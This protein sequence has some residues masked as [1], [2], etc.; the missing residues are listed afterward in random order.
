[1]ANLKSRCNLTELSIKGGSPRERKW[2]WEAAIWQ[3]ENFGKIKWWANSFG[4]KIEVSMP[5]CGWF[6][7]GWGIAV[8]N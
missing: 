8:S 6:V 2:F 3:L 7:W 5:G 1:M 4:V